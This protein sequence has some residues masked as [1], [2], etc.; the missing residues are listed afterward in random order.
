MRHAR[1][2]PGSFSVTEDS[3]A[4]TSVIVPSG[5]MAENPIVLQAREE[6]TRQTDCIQAAVETLRLA[7]VLCDQGIPYAP[8]GSP[9]RVPVLNDKGEIEVTQPDVNALA[10]ACTNKLPQFGGDQRRDEFIK[11][12]QGE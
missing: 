1:V 8:L 9:Y 11:D 5:V 2:T 6:A 10:R 4:V 7:R 12:I 3:T